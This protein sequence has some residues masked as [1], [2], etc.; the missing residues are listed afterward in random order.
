VQFIPDGRIASCGRDRTVKVWNAQGNQVH[1]L[2]PM[3][4]L[5]LKVAMTDG[6]RVAAG[7]WSG[8][9]RVWNAA[10]GK[11]VATL[12]S[13]PPTLAGEKDAVDK[14]AAAK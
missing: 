7:D 3:T 5:A 9:V 4:E 2:G 10:D 1:A 6:G 8:D 12:A 11:Q 14:K 13:N